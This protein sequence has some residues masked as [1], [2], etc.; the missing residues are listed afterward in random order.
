MMPSH[1]ENDHSEQNPATFAVCGNGNSPATFEAAAA[2]EAVAVLASA[3]AHSAATVPR[4]VLSLR[5]RRRDHLVETLR[6]RFGMSAEE[7]TIVKRLPLYGAEPKRGPGIEKLRVIVSLDPRLAERNDCNNLHMTL[8][9]WGR[10]R[11][12]KPI[13]LAALSRVRRL[14]SPCRGLID[15]ELNVDSD[16]RH[17]R[18]QDGGLVHC[19]R[20]RLSALV[21]RE[22]RSTGPS[23]E[24][25][26]AAHVTDQ[27]DESG[28]GGLH[29]APADSHFAGRQIRLL[30]GRVKI[31][32]TRTAIQ[33]NQS[34]QTSLL[35]VPVAQQSPA[36]HRLLSFVSTTAHPLE[37]P[38]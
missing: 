36:Y 9:Y 15:F 3:T 38:E 7:L 35:R 16:W 19:L 27:F 13:R 34:F 11:L 33:L 2:A 37:Y 8:G 25:I 20:E 29:D 18:V 21:G 5:G 17:G 12:E 6:D 10:K 1:T 14:S 28:D 24:N 22:F 26:L 31:F 32:F 4:Q 23:P 30:R